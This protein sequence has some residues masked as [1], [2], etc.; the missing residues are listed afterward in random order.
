MKKAADIYAR[1]NT[2]KTGV[3]NSN[4]LYSYKYNEDIFMKKTVLPNGKNHG[5]VFFLDWSGSMSDNMK[6]TMEQ[7]ICLALFCKKAQIPFSV[8]AFSSEYYK[9]TQTPLESVQ[10]LNMN[11]LNVRFTFIIYSY[12]STH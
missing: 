3:I 11:E 6:G 1:A 9:R 7:L 4:L 8:Y 5:M 12:Y 10:S 2:T